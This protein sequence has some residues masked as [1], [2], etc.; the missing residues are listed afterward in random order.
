M[1]YKYKRRCEICQKFFLPKRD[2]QG[3]CVECRVK[4]GYKYKTENKKVVEESEWNV[5]EKNS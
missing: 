2:G 1:K 3:I 5:S 4:Y